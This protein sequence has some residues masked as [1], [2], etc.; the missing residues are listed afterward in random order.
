MVALI[1]GALAIGGAGYW[2][3]LRPAPA[4]TQTARPTQD[5]AAADAGDALR[6]PATSPEARAWDAAAANQKDH[7][8]NRNDRQNCEKRFHMLDLQEIV[9]LSP[10]KASVDGGD[11]WNDSFSFGT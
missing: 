10:R 4:A 8:K 3:F 7:D 11:L 2:F 6:P 5:D 9:E 1:V